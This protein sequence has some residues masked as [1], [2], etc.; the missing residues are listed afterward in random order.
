VAVPEGIPWAK[1]LKKLTEYRKSGDGEGGEGRIRVAGG[2]W[3][4]ERG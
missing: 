1:L 2:E 4:R 3:F